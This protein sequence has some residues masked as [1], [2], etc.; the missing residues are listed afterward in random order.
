MKTWRIRGRPVVV[1]TAGG[2][3]DLVASVGVVVAVDDDPDEQ[4]AARAGARRA[5]RRAGRATGA[6]EAGVVIMTE[7]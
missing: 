1:L 2:C 7:F 4:A 3:E 6:V 5:R